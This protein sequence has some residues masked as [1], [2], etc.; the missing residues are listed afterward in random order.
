MT[1]STSIKDFLPTLDYKRIY[2]FSELRK[3]GILVMLGIVLIAMVSIAVMM[4]NYYISI[5]DSIYTI[6]THLT[7][8]DIS[9]IPSLHNI[10]I[11]DLRIPRIIL[12]FLIGGSL[13]IA[14]TVYQSVFRNPLV[15]PYILGASSGAAFGAALSIVYPIIGVSIQLSAFCFGA[16]AVTFAYLLA[17]VQGE[18][19]I[20]TLIL[21]GVIIGSIF[22]AFVSLLKYLS[23]DSALREIVFWLMG[24]FYYATWDDIILLAPVSIAGFL[25]LL[26]MGWK[27]NILS[28]GDE[29]ARSLGVNPERYKFIAIAVATALTAFSV[30]LVGI[31][32][33][34]GLMMPHASRILLGPDNRYVIPASFMMGGMYVIVSDTLARILTS[35]EIPVGIITS[36]LGAPYLCYLLRSKGRGMFG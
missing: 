17:R 24:G 27:L 5:T 22:T 11:W 20:F 35:S 9:T 32:A 36:V 34:V 3:I 26:A 1:A 16:L 13:A 23:D 30:S 25:I 4:G 2:N 12:S 21:A 10:V 8:G 18:T 15:E 7:F 33:W 14:G 31:I 19:P 6:I 28:M 29:E